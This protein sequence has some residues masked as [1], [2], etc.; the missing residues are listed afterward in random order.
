MVRSLGRLNGVRQIILGLLEAQK[1]SF[2]ISVSNM[3]ETLVNLLI[4]KTE[5]EIREVK[6]VRIHF[7]SFLFIIFTFY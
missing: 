4:L 7:T 2:N 6:R 1:V 5:R 3:N